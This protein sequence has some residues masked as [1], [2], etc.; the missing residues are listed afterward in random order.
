MWQSEDSYCLLNDW[1]VTPCQPYGVTPRRSNGHQHN[2]LFNTP[3]TWKIPFKPNPQNEPP[4]KYKT[5]VLYVTHANAKHIFFSRCNIIAFLCLSFLQRSMTFC[6]RLRCRFTTQHFGPAWI[7]P[8]DILFTRIEIPCKCPFK[9]IP[10]SQLV[11]SGIVP[12]SQVQWFG[13]ASLSPIQKS[14]SSSLV[15]WSSYTESR[16][17]QQTSA[18]SACRYRPRWWRVK[19]HRE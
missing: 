19:L 13:L 12:F 7:G 9:E 16:N 10:V 5:N 2:A 17:V 3:I 14:L 18:L 8:K 4:H 11:V 1:T 15:E 6:I